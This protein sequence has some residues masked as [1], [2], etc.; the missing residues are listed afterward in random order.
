MGIAKADMRERAIQAYLKQQGT[1]LQIASSYGIHIRTFQRWL[2][3]HDEP[4][5]PHHRPA[6]I[7][8][9]G[10]REPR[11]SRRINWCNDM[12]MLRSQNSTR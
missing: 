7:G 6:V 3:R 2:F 10:T 12:P 8:L 1:Q 4:E 11:W 5:S 9:R